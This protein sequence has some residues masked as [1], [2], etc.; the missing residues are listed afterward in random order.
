MK[1]TSGNSKALSLLYLILPIRSTLSLQIK[2]ILLFFL[3][4]KDSASTFVQYSDFSLLPPAWIAWFLRILWLMVKA[5]YSSFLSFL[6]HFLHCFW[7]SFCVLIKS[8]HLGH[9]LILTSL[10]CPHMEIKETTQTFSFWSC[11][12]QK[13]LVQ[14]RK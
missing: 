11:L 9:S 3:N 4:L 1:L 12:Y 14:K 6:F 10:Y 8:F 5:P 13:T 2:E 7:K